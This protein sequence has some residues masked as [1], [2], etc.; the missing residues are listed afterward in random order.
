MQ[1]RGAGCRPASD[2]GAGVVDTQ[3]A[4]LAACSIDMTVDPRAPGWTIHFF[5]ANF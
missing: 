5:P 2:R 4:A 3:P 1:Y